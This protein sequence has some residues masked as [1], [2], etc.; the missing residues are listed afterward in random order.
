MRFV[1]SLVA[2]V[3]FK[4]EFTFIRVKGFSE[5]P[6]TRKA[7]ATVTQRT[8]INRIQYKGNK[9]ENMQNDN[10]FHII[11]LEL[12]PPFPPPFAP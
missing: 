3:S 5:T 6:T 4:F 10:D 12:P 8:T 7:A 2:V 11:Q 1:V 9:N